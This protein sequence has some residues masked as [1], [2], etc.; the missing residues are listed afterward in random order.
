MGRDRRR[1]HGTLMANW[2]I[3]QN[4]GGCNCNSSNCLSCSPCCIPLQNL[5]FTWTCGGSCTS[6]NCSMTWN[7]LSTV[8]T[9]KWT[10]CCFP[11]TGI[12][13][14]FWVA[15]L[16]CNAG[17]I[18]L[19]INYYSLGSTCSGSPATACTS[20]SG[21]GLTLVTAA[22]VCSP[23]HLQYTPSSSGTCNIDFTSLGFTQLYVDV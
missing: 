20:L 17:T 6:N 15:V 8:A 7:G 19:A 11:Q 16:S 14:G 23:F 2:G 4:P 18:E 9:A 1:L 5:V 21:G 10:S 22:T 13:K 12:V 3:F